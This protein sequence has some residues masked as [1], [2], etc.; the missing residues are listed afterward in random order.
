MNE[1]DY[2]DQEKLLELLNKAFDLRIKNHVED[3]IQ[4]HLSLIDQV[5][6]NKILD[7]IRESVSWTDSSKG[8][9]LS[10]WIEQQAK[11]AADHYIRLFGGAP[12]LREIVNNLWETNK[13]KYI[14]DEVNRRIELIMKDL[15]KTIGA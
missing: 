15:R 13:E 5:V 7:L 14:K 9:E 1:L 3:S 2:D 11:S 12:A 8:G 10:K 6:K 4:R